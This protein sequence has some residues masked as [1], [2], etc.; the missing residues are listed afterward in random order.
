[1]WLVH[2]ETHS[3]SLGQYICFCDEDVYDFLLTQKVNIRMLATYYCYIASSY[4]F[5]VA[6]P[7]RWAL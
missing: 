3:L 6:F 2:G 1:M 5:A 7:F 4:V